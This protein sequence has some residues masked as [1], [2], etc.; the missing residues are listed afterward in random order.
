MTMNFFENCYVLWGQFLNNTL[1]VTHLTVKLL[2]HILCT[3]GPLYE[4]FHKL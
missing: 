2:S 3:S 4:T 1:T